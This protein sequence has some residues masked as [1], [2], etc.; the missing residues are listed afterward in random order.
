MKTFFFV[1][2]RLLWLEK[3]K[4]VKDR[5]R[6][7]VVQ[8][9]PNPE[10]PDPEKNV[11]E[12]VGK[13]DDQEALLLQAVLVRHVTNVENVVPEKNIEDRTVSTNQNLQKK[14]HFHDFF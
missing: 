7:Q 9:F 11:Q 8:V 10:G 4:F 6:H 14:L 12:K 5:L 2:S 13:V 1:F 3:E